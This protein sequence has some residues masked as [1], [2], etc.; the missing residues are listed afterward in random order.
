[1]PVWL[2]GSLNSRQI[3]NPLGRLMVAKEGLQRLDWNILLEN[4]RVTETKRAVSCMGLKALG[5]NHSPL[6]SMNFIG[7]DVTS[8]V[9]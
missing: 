5:K 8:S 6:A 3:E 9:G 4:W 7:L 2:G 1:M